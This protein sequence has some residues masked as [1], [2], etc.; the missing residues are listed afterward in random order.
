MNKVILVQY[1][2]RTYENLYCL[3]LLLFSCESRPVFHFS[4]NLLTFINNS[5]DPDFSLSAGQFG[6][7]E[8]SHGY[9]NLTVWLSD[10]FS[11]SHA[12]F[13]FFFLY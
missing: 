11:T 12:L 13:F 3:F 10:C 9:E 4:P 1:F 2:L 5:V 8:F 6:K 7:L